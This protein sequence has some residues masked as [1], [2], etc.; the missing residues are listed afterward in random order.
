MIK[1]KERA[2]TDNAGV[3]VEQVACALA[4]LAQRGEKGMY[5]HGHADEPLP[6]RGNTLL[7]C[8]VSF[9]EFFYDMD[10]KQ[11]QGYEYRAQYTDEG[12]IASG[13]A[14]SFLEN[15]CEVLASRLEALEPSVYGLPAPLTAQKF[16]MGVGI[17]LHACPPATPR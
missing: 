2:W 8:S 7:R 13:A 10:G 14:R 11:K 12:S 5:L 1:T 6:V 15:T 9:D 16:G 4:S 3:F 17:W